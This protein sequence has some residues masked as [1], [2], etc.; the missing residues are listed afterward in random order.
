LLRRYHLWLR[1]L[2]AD[3]RAKLEKAPAD[4]KLVLIANFSD[5]QR[6]A[7]RTP[8][9]VWP[10]LSDLST[11]PIIEEAYHIKI[12]RNLTTEQ[13]NQ[14]KS[15]T[16]A[17][18]ITKLKR[19]AAD[20]KIESLWDD[21][22]ATQAQ[23]IEDVLS[24][25]FP[26]RDEQEQKKQRENLRALLSLLNDLKNT[27]GAE[28]KKRAGK[29]QK[30]QSNP[31][32]VRRRI[33][34]VLLRNYQSAHVDGRRLQRFMNSI[35]SWLRE[36]IDTLPPDA[37][38]VRMKVLYRLVDPEHSDPSETKESPKSGEAEKRSGGEKAPAPSGEKKPRGGANP[39]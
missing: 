19:M 4:Q 1:T 39:F 27:P 36:S 2:T 13:K 32:I 7:A 20:L 37:A 35:P 6:K 26:K 8:Q 31:D 25:P 18:R 38:A 30:A 14:F 33:D 9:V 34:A 22:E 23:L 11:V 17:A 28:V 29:M 15:G 12:W 16:A 10:Q 3:Q 24:R 5:A 21:L